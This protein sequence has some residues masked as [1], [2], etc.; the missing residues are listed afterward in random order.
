MPVPASSNSHVV[1]N[2]AAV[3]QIADHLRAEAVVAQQP[4]AAA[5]DDGIGPAEAGEAVP[6]FHKIPP[7]FS[8]QRRPSP[9]R[10]RRS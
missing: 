8:A 7:V 10:E 9:H 3:T 1:R 5:H 2:A 6:G 4:I